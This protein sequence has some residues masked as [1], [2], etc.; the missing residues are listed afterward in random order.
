M[1]TGP[2]PAVTPSPSTGLDNMPA[3]RRS[4]LVVLKTR[5]EARAEELAGDLGVTVSAMRQHLSGLSSDGLV[6]HREVRD[7]RGRPRHIY[8]VTPKADALF[9]RTYP[10]LANELL[11]Y[12][13][14]ADHELLEKVF[15]RR[16]DRRIK[17]A[18]ARLAGR[19]FEARV[20]ELTRILDEDGY[21]ATVKP[22]EDGGYMIV[23]H[24]CAILGVAQR[25]GQACSSEIEFIRSVLP[26]AQV[27]RVSH[28]IAG[29]RHCAY[30]VQ[31]RERRAPAWA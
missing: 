9:P 29:Q 24:N 1:T 12:V 26:D 2:V 21:L 18:S 22:T 17:Q 7:G 28:I 11:G 23:E 3:T 10:E 25:Y 19:D 20:E 4:I 27:S 6:D 31:P 8:F 15:R 13:D 30:L 5:G 14:E 16:R